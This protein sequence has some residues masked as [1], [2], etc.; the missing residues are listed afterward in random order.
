MRTCRGIA[1]IAGRAGTAEPPIWYHMQL[2]LAVQG[3]VAEL[4]DAGDLK[5]SASG[6]VGSS[7]TAPTRVDLRKCRDFG[8]SAVAS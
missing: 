6:L 8:K 4:A 3:S 7:P 1:S 2:L 5:S